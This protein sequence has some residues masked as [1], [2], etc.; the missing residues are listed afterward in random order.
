MT[1]ACRQIKLRRFVF[2]VNKVFGEHSTKPVCHV[3]IVIHQE[4]VF[5]L[6]RRRA[7]YPQTIRRKRRFSEP[8]RPVDIVTESR[9]QAF[10][11]RITGL[12]FN[13]HHVS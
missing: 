3:G 12:V 4:A 8:P 13:Q 6:K 10:G 9:M 7:F 11:G 5:Y 1:G 2:K